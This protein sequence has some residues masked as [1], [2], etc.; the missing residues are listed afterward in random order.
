VGADLVEALGDLKPAS[1]PGRGAPS[2][3]RPGPHLV[4][5]KPS[6]AAAGR[7]PGRSRCAHLR[8]LDL[9]VVGP[10]RAPLEPHVA[11]VEAPAVLVDRH[12]ARASRRRGRPRRCEVVDRQVAVPVEDVEGVAELGERPD[13]RARRC[14]GA[15]GRRRSSRSGRPTWSRRRIPRR[16]SP[17][18]SRRRGRSASGPPAF[19]S[20]SWWE[21][22]GS[23][24]TSTRSFGTFSVIGLSRVARPPA[25][26]ATGSSEGFQARLSS[27]RRPWCPRS[28]SGSGPPAGPSRA[29]PGGASSCRRRRT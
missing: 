13:Q 20:R 6:K 26:M 24:A 23:P 11:R 17:R 10:D 8:Q 28:R 25:R 4:P 15:W 27:A 16:S 3:P 7:R 2:A 19:S 21:K 14:R 5:G 12:E 9:L 22:K 29:S 18:G 1:W